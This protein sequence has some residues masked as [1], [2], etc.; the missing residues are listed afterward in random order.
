MRIR[1]AKKIA[2]RWYR[3]PPSMVY[4]AQQKWR[5]R[6]NRY[7]RKAGYQYWIPRSIVLESL[8]RRGV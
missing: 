4:R 5:T 6:L 7:L 2:K 3:Y 1:V 8:T